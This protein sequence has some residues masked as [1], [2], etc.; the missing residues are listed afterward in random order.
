MYHKF[1]Y[2]STVP[3]RPTF[4]IFDWTPSKSKALPEGHGQNSGTLAAMG[5]LKHS[6]I[7]DT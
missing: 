4:L 5:Q 1:Y 3:L 2:A 6:K 7:Y